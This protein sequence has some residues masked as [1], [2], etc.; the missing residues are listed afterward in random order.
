VYSLHSE[1]NTTHLSS[2]VTS[3]SDSSAGNTLTQRDIKRLTVI[4]ESKDSISSDAGRS[5]SSNSLRRKTVPIPTFTAFKDPMP[6][7][8]LLEETTTPVDPKRVFSALMKEIDSTK[9]RNTKSGLSDVSPGAESDVFE[10]ST[11]KELH[12][13]ASREL[14]S[15]TSRECRT[16]T[17]SD[18][19]PVSR[20]RPNTAQSKPSSV[21]SL[22]R[23]LKS[24]IRTVTPTEHKSSPFPDQAQAGDSSRPRTSASRHTT[25]SRQGNTFASSVQKKHVQTWVFRGLEP[26]YREDYDETRDHANSSQRSVHC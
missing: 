15:S 11:T 2:R 25:S 9:A 5:I 6:M 21:R 17:S 13:M 26:P 22:G 16:S 3:W 18:Q 14:H 8:S 10:S 7:E 23:A 12:A 20:C 24:T 4:H 1:T 19:R